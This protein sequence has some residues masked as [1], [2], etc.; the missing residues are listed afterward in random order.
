VY[1]CHHATPKEQAAAGFGVH[2]DW[3]I[4]LLEGYDYKYL[5]NVAH[6]PS[7]SGF[8]GMD[9]P[10]IADI[11]RHEHFDAVLVSGW[12]YKG[13]WQAFRACWKTK[14]P[15]MVRGDSHLNTKRHPVKRLLKYPF[16]R[17]FISKMDAC[18]AVG[19][20]SREYYVHYGA[21]PDRVFI[22]PHVVDEARFASEAERLALV[23]T[24]LRAGWGI[25]NDAIVYVFCGKLNDQKRP[26]DFVQAIGQAHTQNPAI[27]GIVVGDGPLRPECETLATTQQIPI[28]FLG[29]LNQSDLPKAYA[30]AD[31]LILPSDARETWGLVV[32]EAMLSGL[33]ALVSDQVGSGPDLIKS[34]QTG[35][36]FQ[37]GEV[38]QLATQMVHYAHAPAMLR[39]MGRSACDRVQHEYGI[40]QAVDGV[41]DALE[42]VAKA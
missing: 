23:R 1:Y 2:F 35:D 30:V 26:L 33:P 15:V 36:I 5:T 20:W 12:T 18:V 27:I 39:V 9:V 41:L 13:A 17:W 24:E 31:M 10:E 8:Y 4:P 21:S 25:S 6:E 22:V 16:Y 34:G 19:Q 32:N 42:R 40:S 3:D 38:T 28:R 11:I 37:M 14:T 7:N 29:F